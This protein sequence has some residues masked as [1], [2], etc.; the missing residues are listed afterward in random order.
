MLHETFII[1][2]SSSF[3]PGWVSLTVETEKQTNG[4]RHA[5][6]NVDGSGGDALHAGP[7]P[8]VGMGERRAQPR[9]DGGAPHHMGH[10]APST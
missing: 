9:M 7:R 5:W 3:N 4:G 2:S 10:A 6:K 1:R 8:A